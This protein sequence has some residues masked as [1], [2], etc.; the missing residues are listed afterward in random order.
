M[1][2]AMNW[3][4]RFRLC[5]WASAH[6]SRRQCPITSSRRSLHQRQ[7]R[8]C[9]ARPLTRPLFT[10]RFPLIL[11]PTQRQERLPELTLQNHLRIPPRRRQQ[12]LA[13]ERTSALES[14]IGRAS[15]RERVE[16]TEGAGAVRR[17]SK[18]GE[19]MGSKN[20][21]D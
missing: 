3:R 2:V 16:N 9:W 8:P 5:V 12:S 19:K 4:W 1:P 7:L 11:L 14:E 17:N 18:K 20:I 15:C 21:R 13:Q 10:R 6:R